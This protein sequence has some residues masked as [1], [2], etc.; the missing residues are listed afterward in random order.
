MSRR[1]EGAITTPEEATRDSTRPPAPERPRRPLSIEIAAAILIVGG[2]AAMVGTVPALLSG[3][4]AAADPGARP[5]IVLI[6]GL[7]AVTLAVGAL[8]RRG[9]V[10]LL[11]INVVAVLLFIELTAI[12]SGSA[13]AALQAILDG[14]VFVALARNRGWFEWQP[15]NE[16]SSR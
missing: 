4:S 14:Y 3:D 2:F 8:V 16:A 1:F 10:W 7:N 12:P 9:Q 13:I 6:L 11:C 5:V 15:P